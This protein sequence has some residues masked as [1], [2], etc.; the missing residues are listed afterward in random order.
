MFLKET[1]DQLSSLIANRSL[2]SPRH[3]AKELPK[4]LAFSAHDTN[5]APLL[6]AFLGSYANQS[7]PPYTAIVLLEL[8]A[9]SEDAPNEEYILKL[10]YKHGWRDTSSE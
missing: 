10:R 1:F 9:P 6:G 5:V 3:R 8:Y 7:K 4:I 2:Q